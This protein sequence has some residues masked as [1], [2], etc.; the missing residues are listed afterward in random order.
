ML[1]YFCCGVSFLPCYTELCWLMLCF[2]ALLTWTTPV[3]LGN[4]RV[5][6]WSDPTYHTSFFRYDV[7]LKESTHTD[8][9]IIYGLH[10]PNMPHEGYLSN[11]VQRHF[12]GLTPN[13]GFLTLM[14][15]NIW[16]NRNPIIINGSLDSWGIRKQ[17]SRR[18]LDLNRSGSWWII[19]PRESRY[20]RDVVLA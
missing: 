1:C 15:H 17:M 13:T 10:A 12:T 8:H 2:F 11:K 20:P 5:K 4:W 16:T 14:D 3:F 6:L 7:T 19:H 18:L 9:N